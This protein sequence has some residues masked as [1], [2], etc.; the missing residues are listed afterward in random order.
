VNAGL[1]LSADRNGTVVSGASVPAILAEAAT[2]RTVTIVGPASISIGAQTAGLPCANCGPA[3]LKPGISIPTPMY[4]VPRGEPLTVTLVSENINYTGTCSFE[5]AIKQGTATITG[6]TRSVAGGCSAPPGTGYVTVWGREP[7]KH[8]NPG[9]GR[10]DRGHGG[11][12]EHL[13]RL[14]ADLDSIKERTYFP[15]SSAADLGSREELGGLAFGMRER[16]ILVKTSCPA[17]TC[18]AEVIEP[19]DL[20]NLQ[21]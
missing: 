3:A 18:E 11:G 10:P 20:R 6:G 12:L 9:P 14:S 5:Y 17:H 16:N 15:H 13:A 8:R 7:A 21:R 19:V 4:V 2:L 1:I